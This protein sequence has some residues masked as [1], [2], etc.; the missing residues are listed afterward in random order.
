MIKIHEAMTDAAHVPTS[1]RRASWSWI[2]GLA[3][4]FGGLYSGCSRTIEEE[5]EYPP[6]RE[7]TCQTWCEI[8]GGECGNFNPEFPP[9]IDECASNCAVGD[10]SR[11]IREEDG[12]DCSESFIAYVD[13]VSTLTCEELEEHWPTTAIERPCGTEHR[14][15]QEC[16]H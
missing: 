5:P 2:V 6:Y 8:V 9:D 16:I 11:W 3:F 10:G 13:C 15:W 14:A 4:A 12:S 1:Q 7:P